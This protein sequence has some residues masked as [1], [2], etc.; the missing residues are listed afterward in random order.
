VVTLTLMLT[1]DKFIGDFTG[2][3]AQAFSNF[4]RNKG[5]FLERIKGAFVFFFLAGPGR[6]FDLITLAETILDAFV[7]PFTTLMSDLAL[8]PAR[9][10]LRSIADG[11]EEELGA[12]Q[13]S[14]YVMTVRAAKA[15]CV[16]EIADAGLTLLSSTN[17]PSTSRIATI[18]L[19]SNR[20][21]G[22]LGT[23]RDGVEKFIGKRFSA[24]F[25]LGIAAAVNSAI[26]LA[27]AASVVSILYV[28]WS[29]RDK[30]PALSQKNERAKETKTGRFRVQK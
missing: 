26:R 1:P 30:W 22:V 8:G 9:A 15:Q 3:I 17:F 20:V 23:I 24:F 25:K 29:N 21:T 2:E 4:S 19:L 18:Y 5:L 6:A 27:L 7:S 14:Q 10:I 12:G 28:V 13:S 11:A 16:R